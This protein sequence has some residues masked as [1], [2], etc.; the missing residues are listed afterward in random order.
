MGESV[1]KGG[2]TKEP[3]NREMEG[4][5]EIN[6]TGG[7]G[8]ERGAAVQ[9]CRRES[10]SS[11]GRDGKEGQMSSAAPRSPHAPPGLSSSG[12]CAHPA[13]PL[14]YKTPTVLAVLENAQSAVLE[15]VMGREKNPLPES[16]RTSI[17][18]HLLWGQ[19]GEERGI[20]KSFQAPNSNLVRCI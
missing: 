3:K 20:V 11:G 7:I 13:N 1:K 4:G 15:A 10:S 2:G 6:G 5:G 16:K 12:F 8:R 18:C 19:R 9:V 14:C 17:Q